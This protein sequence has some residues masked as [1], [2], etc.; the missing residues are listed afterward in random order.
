[1]IVFWVKYLLTFNVKWPV[2]HGVW[3]F[4]ISAFAFESQ[5]RVSQHIATREKKESTRSKVLK[6]NPTFI[7]EIALGNNSQIG[8][9][10]GYEMQNMVQFSSNIYLVT[11]SIIE[12]S[13]LII[14][15]IIDS[16]ICRLSDL[17]TTPGKSIKVRFGFFGPLIVTLIG[18][19]INSFGWWNE[20]ACRISS[21]SWFKLSLSR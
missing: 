2:S 21:V 15:L 19:S 10:F 9:Y 4:F 17:A 13:I 14:G 18:C 7:L 20:F 1:M 6:T 3:I 8:I 16:I 5:R 12:V 11:A